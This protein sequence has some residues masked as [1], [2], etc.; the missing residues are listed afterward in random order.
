MQLDSIRQ[1]VKNAKDKTYRDSHTLSGMVEQIKMRYN[2]DQKRAVEGSKLRLYVK[3]CQPPPPPPSYIDRRSYQD[4]RFPGVKATVTVLGN[5]CALRGLSF[6]QYLLT[7]D[8]ASYPDWISKRS[9]ARPGP[10]RSVYGAISPPGTKT[11]LVKR[12]T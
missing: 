9:L 6:H 12:E 4:N 8:V 7:A 11:E 3:L 5:G 10:H 2:E 1:A